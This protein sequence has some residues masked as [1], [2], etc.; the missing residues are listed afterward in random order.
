M[1]IPLQI[2]VRDV[3]H[4]EALESH[5]REKARKL[6]K[7]SDHIISCRVVVEMPHKHSRQ[8]KQFLVRVD[9][10]VPR[11]EIVINRDHHED[12]YVALRDAFDAARR[13]VEEHMRR[14]R[15]DT[16]V[17]APELV[18]HVQRLFPEDGI[19]FISGPDGT[20]YYFSSE[21]VAS[22]RFAQLKEGDEVKF[23]AELA[24]EG[25]QAKRVSTGR[26]HFPS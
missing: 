10:G 9:V 24:D 3:P 21:D 20:E 6:E 8:G 17:H 19:G 25:P 2:T 1:Q 23:L 12:V 16:K 13:Q 15:Q 4:S 14:M 26:H 11:H 18:G 7:F 5:I 22:P